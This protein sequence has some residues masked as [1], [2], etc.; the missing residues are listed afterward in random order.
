MG[1]NKRISLW[2]V[3]A[4]INPRNPVNNS[5]Q[6]KKGKQVPPPP[7]PPKSARQQVNQLLNEQR[8]K[9]KK[10]TKSDQSGVSPQQSSQQQSVEPQTA[11]IKLVSFDAEAN[12]TA[13]GPSGTAK[14]IQPGNKSSTQKGKHHIDACTSNATTPGADSGGK[15]PA[16]E[17]GKIS[18]NN[19]RVGA[20]NVLRNSIWQDWWE[21]MAGVSSLGVR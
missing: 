20:N 11:S 9:G 21:K 2:T 3:F 16:S 13:A 19:N 5:P 7:Q 12:K 18:P 1:F 15:A 10:K 8:Q 4:R 14:S 6:K 17:E